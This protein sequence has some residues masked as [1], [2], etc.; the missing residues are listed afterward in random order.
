M[1]QPTLMKVATQKNSLSAIMRPVKSLSRLD[2]SRADDGSV[3]F[4]TCE[5][6]S[7]QRAKTPASFDCLIFINQISQV[8]GLEREKKTAEEDK[9]AMLTFILKHEH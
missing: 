5:E 1:L 9:D 7:P 2:I 3:I 6:Y 8:H 4:F